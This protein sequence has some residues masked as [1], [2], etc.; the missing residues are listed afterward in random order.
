[1]I[2]K[3]HPFHAKTSLVAMTVF[4][5]LSAFPFFAAFYVPD[6]NSSLVTSYSVLFMVLFATGGFIAALRLFVTRC[7][8][9]KNWL[10][11]Q[12]KFHEVDD[13]KFFCKKC[14]VVWNTGI[15]I[16]K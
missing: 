10:L 14:G 7:P 6:N 16:D 3:T 15:K 2:E 8:D 9:C 5:I 11:R 4:F 12:K 13:L 1:M